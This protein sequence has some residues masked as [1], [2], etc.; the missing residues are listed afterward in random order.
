M[1]LHKD[2]IGVNLTSEPHSVSK[3]PASSLFSC[4]A[5]GKFLALLGLRFPIHQMAGKHSKVSFCYNT[6]QMM[7]KATSPSLLFP[8]SA[9][10]VL[11]STGSCF[12]GYGIPSSAAVPVTPRV[13]RTLKLPA[14]RSFPPS[15]SQVLFSPLLGGAALPTEVHGLMC[16][17]EIPPCFCSTFSF[18]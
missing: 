8:C 2:R 5:S 4:A 12:V 7:S 13:L 1:R 11:Q 17:S 14:D 16:K 10:S 3:A 6:F 15:H 9:F 18:P